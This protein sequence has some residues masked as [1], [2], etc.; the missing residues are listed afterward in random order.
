M[1]K[2]ATVISM[3]LGL[4]FL[5]CQE[6]HTQYVEIDRAPA[7]PQGVYSVTAD[8]TVYVYWLPVRE[9]DLSHYRVFRS[10]NDVD[11][12]YIGSTSKGTEEYVDENLANGTTYYY[13]ISS[14]DRAGNESELSHETVFDTPRPEGRD[15]MLTDFNSF[16]RDAGYDFS[17]YSIVPYNSADADFYVEL[18]QGIFYINVADVQTDIQ[19]MGYTDNFDEISYSPTNPDGWSKVGWSEAILGHTY[20]IWTSNDH[21]AKLRVTAIGSNFVRFDWGYQVSQ[22]NPELARPQHGD[23]YLR[24]TVGLSIVK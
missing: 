5:G 14:V 10:L 24:R 11:Y 21:Y 12:H 20:I 4:G 7:A 18:T 2:I 13:A 15:L 6:N 22:G 23:G 16:P 9:S 1:N 17:T 8:Q 19:D 3:V